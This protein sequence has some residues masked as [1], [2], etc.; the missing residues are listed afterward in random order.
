MNKKMTYRN[1]DLSI[2]P[3]EKIEGEIVKHTRTNY[4][5]RES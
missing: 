1:G 2:I 4:E 3:T 5:E